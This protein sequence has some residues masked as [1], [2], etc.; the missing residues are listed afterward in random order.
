MNSEPLDPIPLSALQH[1]AYCPRQCAL[2]HVEQVFE[3]NIFT[4]R[5]QA[6][7]KRVDD[8]G[9]ELRNGLRIERALPLFCDRLGLVGK[10][11]VVEFLPDGTPVDIVL[12][13]LGVPSRMNV[14][15]ILEVHLGWAG[16]LLGKQ[17]DDLIAEKKMAPEDV[18]R[19]NHAMAREVG[20]P[21]MRGLLA[22]AHGDADGAVAALMPARALAQRLVRKLCTHCH[23]AGC[24]ECAHTGYSG[25]T[26]VFELLVTTDAIRA[27]IHAQASEA[28]IRAAAMADGMALMRE[29]GER[30]IAAGIT[31]REEVLRVTRD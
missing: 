7:H 31:S 24:A 8:P 21:L 5:G 3:E 27:Q 14:G 28:D 15:Q 11:D 12:N 22:Y 2:I 9:F 18:R 13:P 26:G 29:D 25:R 1:W 30:L 23:G 17:L 10:A 19:S 4:Q 6:L 20:Q 16:L